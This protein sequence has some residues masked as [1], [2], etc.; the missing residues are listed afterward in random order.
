MLLDTKACFEFCI[1]KKNSL[2]KIQ[3]NANPKTKFM[4]S[5]TPIF[6]STP[7]KWRSGAETCRS[8]MYHKLC[9]VTGILL[10]F[11]RCICWPTY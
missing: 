10:C 5:V 4:I 3:Q 11:I 9:F 2:H 6:F 8:D 7:C 1:D